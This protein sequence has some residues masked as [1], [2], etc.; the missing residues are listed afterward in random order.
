MPVEAEERPEKLG[1]ALTTGS[2]V[3]YALF[4][5][6]KFVCGATGPTITTSERKTTKKIPN[7]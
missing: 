7:I 2:M 5:A 1:V 3:A 6:N 4:V